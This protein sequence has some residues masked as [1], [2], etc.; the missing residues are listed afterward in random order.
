[1]KWR[2]RDCYPVMFT[3]HISFGDFDEMIWSWHLVRDTRSVK[4]NSPT[5]FVMTACTDFSTYLDFLFQVGKMLLLDKTGSWVHVTQ[6]SY[7]LIL[8]KFMLPW[9]S[10]F[11]VCY[12]FSWFSYV[13]GKCCICFSQLS[14]YWV[15][16]LKIEPFGVHFEFSICS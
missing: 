7:I 4:W 8:I 9:F 11:C 6:N 14:H 10:L 16:K 5:K 3:R 13:S 1:M 2:S 15:G 12:S